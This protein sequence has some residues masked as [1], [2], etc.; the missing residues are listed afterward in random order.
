MPYRSCCAGFF[1]VLLVAKNRGV[2]LGHGVL[3]APPSSSRRHGRSNAA[4][5][6]H[7]SAGQSRI[8]V[9]EYLGWTNP[10]TF[11]KIIRFVDSRTPDGGG[12]SLVPIDPF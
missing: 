12:L 10:L 7:L 5:A 6:R 8:I 3:A 1:G 11:V 4:A 9:A 2:A